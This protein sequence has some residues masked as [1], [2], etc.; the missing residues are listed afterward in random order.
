MVGEEL[1][2]DGGQDWREDFRH[3]RNQDDV[4]ADERELLSL[5]FGSDGDDWTATS[6]DLL[7]VAEV[8]RIDGIVRSD[9][10]GGCL[11]IDQ[12]DDTML[13]F[14]AGVTHG[15]NVA[16]LLELEGSLHGDRVVELTPHEEHDLGL[17]IALGDSSNLRLELEHLLDLI[18]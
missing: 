9:D 1:E 7:N 13:E 14:G 17:S 3:I 18:G 11:R 4:V 2:D 15:G 5:T 16:D 10:H 12:G 8:L 6:L